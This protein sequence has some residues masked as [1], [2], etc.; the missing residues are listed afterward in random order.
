MGD[1]EYLQELYR[2]RAEYADME[3]TAADAKKFARVGGVFWHIYSWF[4]RR[5]ERDRM[6][7]QAE[8]DEL[9]RPRRP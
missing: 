6:E 4:E 2:E 3:S 8:I 7:V 5:F 9:T 1:R